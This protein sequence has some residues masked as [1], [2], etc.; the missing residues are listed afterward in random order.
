MGSLRNPAGWCNIYGFRPSWGRVPSGPDGETF[1]HT[2]ATDGPMARCPADLA[3]LLD[4]MAGPV[5]GRPFGLPH[6]PLAGRL[7]AEMAGRRVAWL[8]DWGGAFPCAPGVLE[9]CT[10]ALDE[11]T[12]LGIDVAVPAPPMDAEAMWQSWVTLRHWAV[13]ARLG[14]FFDA[15]A[16]RS[17]LKPAA[18]WEIEQGRALSRT[19]IERAG[20]I[21]SDWYRRADA[22]F[23]RYDALILPTAQLWPFPVETV[24]PTEING[25]AMDSYH[26]W[27]QVV[28]PASLIGLPSVAVPAGFGANGLPMGLQIIGRHGDDLGVLQLAEAWHRATDWPNRRPPE[29]A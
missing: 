19:E 4:T 12:G 26:R 28:V 27:M 16:K 13:Q 14:V 8:G 2:L 24:H 25:A 21:R 7:G 3:A 15:P 5:P 22:L 6:E 9:T 11:M 23:D 20:A 10:A 18:L 17:H 29:E 1:F